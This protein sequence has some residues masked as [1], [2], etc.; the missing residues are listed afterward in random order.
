MMYVRFVHNIVLDSSRQFPTPIWSARCEESFAVIEES[1]AVI[2]VL[3]SSGWP[4]SSSHFT[5]RVMWVG[6][7]I[8]S[9]DD[10]HVLCSKTESC[11][12]NPEVYELEYLH[13]NGDK[14]LWTNDL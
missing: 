13:L 8:C 9:S 3:R 14:L 12:L 5:F 2:F 6:W 1:F 4:V 11:S 7:L 10:D